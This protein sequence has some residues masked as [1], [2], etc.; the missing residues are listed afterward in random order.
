MKGYAI[1]SKGQQIPRKKGLDQINWAASFSGR[2]TH[3]HVGEN[4]GGRKRRGNYS[5]KYASKL[6]GELAFFP[7]V[8]ISVSNQEG[9]N[10]VVK[11][12]FVKYIK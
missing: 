8:L 3:T 11:Y 2:D 4:E 6:L 12:I 5:Q 9:V 1:K 7:C 10:R